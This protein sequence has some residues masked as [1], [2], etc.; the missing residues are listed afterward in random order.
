MSRAANVPG[1]RDVSRYATAL[2]APTRVSTL[3]ATV[4]GLVVAVTLRRRGLKPL[5]RDPGAAEGVVDPGACREVSGAVDAALGVLPFKPTCLRRSMTLLR[6]L[7]RLA[8][9]AELHIGVRIV[10]DQVEAHAWVVAG[11]QV[12]NDDPLLIRTYDE[13][14]SGELDR[15]LPMLR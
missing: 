2:R 9:R 13:L 7:R 5:L 12:V 15:F 6:E 11:R 10:A 8:L 3:R 14:V 1:W 4:D